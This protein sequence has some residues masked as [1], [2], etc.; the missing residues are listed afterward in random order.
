MKQ[1]LARR[2]GLS[3]LNNMR[4]TLTG[5]CRRLNAAWVRERAKAAPFAACAA[6]V[7]AVATIGAS[8]TLGVSQTEA[9][10]EEKDWVSRSKV[11]VSSII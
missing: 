6:G 8:E 3:G 7:G 2:S 10:L 5:C 11:L 1:A 9:T 4:R